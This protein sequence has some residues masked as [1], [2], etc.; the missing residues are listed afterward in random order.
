M[1]NVLKHSFKFLVIKVYFS[2]SCLH[3]RVALYT[4]NVSGLKSIGVSQLL[5]KIV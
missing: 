5:L 1:A 3:A 2:G 4:E